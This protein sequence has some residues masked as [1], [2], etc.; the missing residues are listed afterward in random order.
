MTQTTKS[1]DPESGTT[2]PET[3]RHSFSL[4]TKL[5]L[6]IS[7]VATALVGCGMLL[8]WFT[9]ELM[10]PQFTLEFSE[11]KIMFHQYPFRPDLGI[12]L[13]VE[14]L[15][16]FAYFLA[17]ITQE[18]EWWPLKTAAAAIS[19]YLVWFETPVLLASWLFTFE[20]VYFAMSD[21]FSIFFL[22]GLICIALLTFL[23]CRYP[24]LQQ[25]MARTFAWTVFGLFLWWLIIL[26]AI[27]SQPVIYPL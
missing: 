5:G 4:A 18:T 22:G 21:A 16:I 8:H 13:M 2:T 26:F 6:L 11:F 12:F 15:L 23:V 14:C 7:L 27:A 10:I 19:T 25:R 20:R 9:I 24:K 17:R 1:V 3:P